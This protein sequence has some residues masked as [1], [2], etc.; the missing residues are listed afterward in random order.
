MC[1]NRFVKLSVKFVNLALIAVIIWVGAYLFLESKKPA[2][3]AVAPT[4]TVYITPTNSPTPTPVNLSSDKLFQLVNEWRAQN[5]YQAFIYS[6]FAESIAIRRLP[7]VKKDWSHN[8]FSY[9][10]Y[11]DSC[12]LG[13]N[14]SRGYLTEPEILNAWLNSPSHRENLELPFSHSAIVCDNTEENYCV[15]IFSFF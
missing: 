10:K 4:P 6:D 12:Y 15:H 1:Y 9:E 8:G 3:I 2:Y 5:G 11:C 14:L 13:E 7:E